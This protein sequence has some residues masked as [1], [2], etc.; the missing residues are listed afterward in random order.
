[1]KNEKKANIA[2][3]HFY[4]KLQI[5]VRH[6]T[7]HILFL[8]ALKVWIDPLHFRVI[9]RKTPLMRKTIANMPY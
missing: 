8:E 1:M 7:G 3:Y 4:K 5:S 9:E 6:K 2:I